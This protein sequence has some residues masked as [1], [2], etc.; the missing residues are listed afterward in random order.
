MNHGA[1]FRHAAKQM[2]K[3]GYLF[4]GYARKSPSRAGDDQE[5]RVRLLNMMVKNLRERLLA[6]EVYV[7]PSCK[8]N[9]KMISR[10][11][12]IA[13]I[14]KDLEAVNGTAQGKLE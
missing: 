14:V 13:E 6:D 3:E 7:S 10:D 11:T 1:K 4:I 5:S 9:E 2:K 8:S 12:G